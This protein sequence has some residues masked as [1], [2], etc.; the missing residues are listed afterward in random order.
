MDSWLHRTRERFWI[1]MTSPCR[2]L[3]ELSHQY[4]KSLAFPILAE[5]RRLSVAREGTHT[6]ALS[7]LWYISMRHECGISLCSSR[8]SLFSTSGQGVKSFLAVTGQV[9]IAP[10]KIW[11][12]QSFRSFPDYIRLVAHTLSSLIILLTEFMYSI[13]TRKG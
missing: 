2:E 3:G 8:S 5:L 1:L 6:F 4:A 9:A 11:C 10:T 13:V 7:M 12:G